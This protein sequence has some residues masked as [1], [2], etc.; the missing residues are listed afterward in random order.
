MKLK[1]S[2]LVAAAIAAI[3]IGLMLSSAPISERRAATPLATDR[4]ELLIW[5]IGYA[6]LGAESDF[7]ADGGKSFLPPSARIVRKNLAGIEQ[8]LKAS[9]ADVI[10]LPEAAR[11]TPLTWWIDVLGALDKALP[12]R[13]RIFSTDVLTKY[14]PWPFRFEHGLAIYSRN[15][16]GVFAAEPL[17]LEPAQAGGLYQRAYSARVVR[18][19]VEGKS[20][21]GLVAVHLAAFDKN[22]EVRRSQL[23]AVFELAKALHAEGVPVII[24]G[25]FNLTLADTAFPNTTSAE[26]RAWVRPFPRDLLPSGWQIV[27]DPTAPSVR[28]NE[29]AYKAGQNYTGVVDGYIVS[30]DVWVEKVETLD[31]KFQYSDHQPVRLI[32]RRAP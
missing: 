23:E 25:D 26:D 13:E 7:V 32:A 2:W 31:L 18:L 22:A 24:G 29:R 19:P 8:T 1:T 17:P 11:G 20:D 28:T 6:G 3:G 16:I 27:T 10:I 4:L 21:W 30:P 12:G 9:T 15:L 5:N 14:L